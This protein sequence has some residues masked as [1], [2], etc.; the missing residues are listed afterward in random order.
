MTGQSIT[1]DDVVFLFRGCDEIE[2]KVKNNA[3]PVEEVIKSFRTLLF[4]FADGNFFCPECGA[5]WSC[6]DN[7][8]TAQCSANK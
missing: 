8:C 3:M 1:K 5:E 4:I 7:R 6:V 2:Y